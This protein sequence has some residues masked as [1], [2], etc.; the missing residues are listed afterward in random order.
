MDPEI[1]AADAAPTPAPSAVTTPKPADAVEGTISHKEIV[2]LRKESRELID[3][4]KKLVAVQAAPASPTAPPAASSG[5]DVGDRIRAEFRAE[6]DFKDQL[7]EAGVTKSQ[8]TVLARLWAAEKPADVGTWL[9]TT[10]SS[11]GIKQGA[12]E[13][14]VVVPTTPSDQGDPAANRGQGGVNDDIRKMTPSEIK[15]LGPQGVKQII[16]R[17]TNGGGVS[18]HYANIKR[19]HDPK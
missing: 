19:A 3:L 8:R 13:V 1:V 2:G 7:I 12:P 6:I 10:M 18:R 17:I 11:L 14:K 16:D 4:V 9:D 5:E 15:T